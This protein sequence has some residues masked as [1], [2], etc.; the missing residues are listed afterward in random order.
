MADAFP[1]NYGGKQ[2][3]NETYIKSFTF[4]I[5]ESLWKTIKYNN[6]M[7]ITPVSNNINNLYI[8]GNLYVDGLIVNP[9]DLTI[10]DNIKILSDD[11]TKNIDNLKPIEFTFKDDE[12][13]NV[14]YGFIAQDFSEIYP[15]L[16]TN[17]PRKEDGRN[18]I[19]GINYL[20][21]V[22]LLVAR[23]QQMQKEIDSL[24]ESISNK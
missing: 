17:I 21:I 9:S 1:A 24:K 6:Q 2:Q 3:D 5:P 16:V 7:A 12:K 11:L 4:G 14:H 20:E 19:L 22:P 10:K 13:K 8:P 23:I 18:D 15:H